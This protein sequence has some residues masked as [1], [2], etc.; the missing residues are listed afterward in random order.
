MKQKLIH[1]ERKNRQIHN[2]AWRRKQSSFGNHTDSRI[3]GQKIVQ[4]IETILP[5]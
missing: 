4:D 5:N 1:S 3:S 2:Y